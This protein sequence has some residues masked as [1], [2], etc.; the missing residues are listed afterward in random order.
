MKS[1]KNRLKKLAGLNENQII[2]IEDP[3]FYDDVPSVRF[4]IDDTTGETLLVMEVGPMTHS[5]DNLKLTV[6]KDRPELYEKLVKTMQSELQ[7]T[8][9]KVIHSILGKPFGLK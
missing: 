1:E 9:R 4:T 7:S 3:T 8:F 5:D 6:L 2:G